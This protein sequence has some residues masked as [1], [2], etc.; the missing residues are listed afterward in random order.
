LVLIPM[1]LIEGLLLFILSR[2]ETPKVKVRHFAYLL[3]G[4]MAGSFL[5]IYLLLKDPSAFVFGNIG[6]HLIWGNEVIRMTLVRKLFTLA[7]FVLYPQN[8][9]ILI[10]A[11][12][13]AVTLVRKTRGSRLNSKD[14][15]MVAALVCGAALIVTF[16]LMSPSQ[17]QY[18]E[19]VLP[20]LLI[21]S[22]PILPRLT[23]RIEK[24]KL[25]AAAAATGY[26]IFVVPFVAIFILGVRQRDK[27]FEIKAVRKVV[28][29][30]QE[31]SGPGEAIFTLWP[32]YALLSKRE[33]EPGLEAWRGG[34]IPLLSPEQITKFKLIDDS[35][36]E[37]MVTRKEVSLILKEERLTPSID[38]LIE[39]NYR[40]VESTGFA[41]VYVVKD[42]Q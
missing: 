30:I 1:L 23:E 22:I 39:T 28:Q 27:P 33:T 32:G 34:V 4:T 3:L 31:N 35:R 38:D 6:Y 9:V 16:F 12:L 26:L 40:L 36:V 21:A 42:H 29:A 14:T 15:V 25:K 11:A 7:K 41:R 5:A 13:G 2:G 37:R 19:Q 20:Y 17:F 8:L 18:Y 10:T 24:R